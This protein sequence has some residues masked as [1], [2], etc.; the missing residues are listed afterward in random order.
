MI[1]SYTASLKSVLD[2]GDDDTIFFVDAA[3]ELVKDLDPDM[4]YFLTGMSTGPCILSFKISPHSFARDV[5]THSVLSF[6]SS[7]YLSYSS[8]SAIII[9]CFSLH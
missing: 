7:P 2:S 1:S 4:P 8:W 5:D 3:M 9:L 6:Y